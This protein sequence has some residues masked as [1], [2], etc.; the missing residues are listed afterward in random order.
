MIKLLVYGIGGTMGHYVVSSSEQTDDMKV[1]CGVDK[2]YKG[3]EFSCPVYPSCDDVIEKPD[4]IIDFSVP[5]G[6]YD[7]LPYA[8]KNKIPCVIAT[9]GFSEDDIAYIQ[10]AAETIP[11]LRSGNLSLGINLL[12]HLCKEAAKKVGDISDIEIIEQHHN[13]KKDAPSG[14]ALLLAD[15][16]KSV[17]PDRYNK[18]GRAGLSKRTPEE[19]GIHAVRGGTIVGKH[20]VMF[21]MNGEVITL[22]HEAENKSILSKGSLTAAR[23]IVTKEKG[24]Y[25]LSDMF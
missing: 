8:I 23:L 5:Q 15:G 1:V 19:I 16:I 4:C 7:Y 6:I 3:N 21:I 24:L 9:T 2:F 17:L 10:K 13:K 25:D 20:S 12:L 18:L 14:T 22:T 11:V